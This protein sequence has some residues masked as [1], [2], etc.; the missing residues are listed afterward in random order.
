M[1]RLLVGGLEFRNLIKVSEFF[2][3]YSLT[4]IFLTFSFGFYVYLITL[5]IYKLKSLTII[6]RVVVVREI[7]VK[8]RISLLLDSLRYR[9]NK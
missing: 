7:W 6:S 3:H 2:I 5:F 8:L 1:N 9:I 4:Y